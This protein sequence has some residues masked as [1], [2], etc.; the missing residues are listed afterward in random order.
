MAERMGFEPTVR[1][2][3]YDDLANRCLQPLGHLSVHKL[4][5]SKVYNI[6]D[7]NNQT[8]TIKKYP[9]PFSPQKRLYTAHLRLHIPSFPYAIFHNIEQCKKRN[10]YMYYIPS[11]SGRGLRL[12]DCFATPHLNLLPKGR[13]SK[14]TL[15]Y[16]VSLSGILN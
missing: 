10:A 1:V 8:K 4:C 6:N 15:R 14:N 13:R 3:T 2:T 7:E 5:S 12:I 16:S 9:P 11:P